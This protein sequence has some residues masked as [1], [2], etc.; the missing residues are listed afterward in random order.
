MDVFKKLSIG[1]GTNYQLGKEVIQS[2]KMR[3]VGKIGWNV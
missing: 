3:T 2:K 1:E